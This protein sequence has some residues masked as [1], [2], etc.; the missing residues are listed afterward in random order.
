MDFGAAEAD[1]D[2]W[3][4]GRP[5]VGSQKHIELDGEQQHT[6]FGKNSY[7]D[8][9]QIEP[10]FLDDSTKTYVND[11]EETNRVSD[12]TNSPTFNEN[13][14]AATKN[15]VNHYKD[16]NDDILQI[17]S[18]ILH[19]EDNYDVNDVTNSRSYQIQTHPDSN[20]LEDESNSHHIEEGGNDVKDFVETKTGGTPYFFMKRKL[21]KNL[22]FFD[23]HI[24]N[25]NLSNI[26]ILPSSVN[27]VKTECFQ[28][29]RV[30][31]E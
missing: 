16:T 7:Q 11:D 12:E 9:P 17:D 8:R 25:E 15:N 20:H 3:D 10:D 22:D 14:H 26:L 30:N 1:L 6:I 19:H 28:G 23:L 21:Y 4:K 18:S 5:S 27:F 24:H 2:T 29:S 31:R 13:I